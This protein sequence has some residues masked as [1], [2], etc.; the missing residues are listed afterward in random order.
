MEGKK[1]VC[2]DGFQLAKTPKG[3][4]VLIYFLKMIY[5]DDEQGLTILDN[6]YMT[7]KEHKSRI[8]DERNPKG[9]LLF[10]SDMGN[11]DVFQKTLINF[12]KEHDLLGDCHVDYCNCKKSN[13]ISEAYENALINCKKVGI[14]IVLIT[15][16][17]NIK[18]IPKSTDSATFKR[19]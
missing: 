9:C 16:A 13:K 18:V 15:S 17:A 8:S 3:I 19:E 10:T 14:L 7:Q 11:I 4:K 5:D 6:I 1:K 2:K 12:I